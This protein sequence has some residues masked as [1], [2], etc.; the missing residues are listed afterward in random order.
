MP[1]FPH[2]RVWSRG[3]LIIGVVIYVWYT[4]TGKET[5]LAKF[6]EV[7]PH[8]GQNVDCDDAYLDEI[9]QYS[10]CVPAHCGRYVSDKLVTAN[11]A[12]ILL[13][14]AKKGYFCLLK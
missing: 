6:K 8:R 11:E 10:N 12:E 14:I 5:V 13:K 9:K 1:K 7:L 3:I 4:S 2:Q